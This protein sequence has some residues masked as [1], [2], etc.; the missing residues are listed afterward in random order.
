MAVGITSAV[1]KCVIYCGCTPSMGDERR[2]SNWVS[3]DRRGD[4]V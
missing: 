4:A 1:G 2:N 3:G